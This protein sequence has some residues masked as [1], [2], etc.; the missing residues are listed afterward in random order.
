[1]KKYNVKKFVIASLLVAVICASFL[2]ILFGTDKT[3]SATTKV[4]V[5]QGKEVSVYINGNDVTKSQDGNYVAVAGSTITVTV[6]NESKLFSSMTIN[7]TKY[8]TAVKT[9]TVPSDNNKLTI[10]VDTQEP[11][12]EDKGKYF[13]NPYVLNKEA[14]VLAVARILAG[15]TNESDFAQIGA[16]GKTPDD[17]RYGYYRLG[18]NLFISSQ[19]FFGLGFRGALPFGGCFD[20]DGYI[21]TMNLVRTSHVDSEFS[22]E[23]DTHVADYG[24][25]AYAYGDGV[26]P[27]LIKNVKLQ[28]FIG[29]NTM[30]N[31]ADSE[32]VDHVN[33]GSVAGSAGKNIVFD[34]IESSVSVSAQTRYAD[35]YIG[36]IFGMCSSS[37]EEWCDVR[38]DGAFNDVSGVTY[39]RGAGVVVGAFAGVVQNASIN[40]ITIDGERSMILANALGE[41]SGSA[42]AGGFVGVI[43]LGA[44]TYKEI[45]EPRAMIIKNITIYAES[46]YSVSSVINNSGATQKNKIDPDDFKKTSSAAIAGGIL[47]VVNRGSNGSTALDP[48]MDIL[49]SKV[50]F[51]RS[52]ETNEGS[53]D[54]DKA[55]NGR[56]FIKASTQDAESS[57]VV[58]AGGVVGYIY[59]AGNDYITKKIHELNNVEYIFNCP[60]DITAE[61]NGVGPAYAGGVFGYNSFK[62][63]S[64]DGKVLKI[65]VVS[66]E[67]DYTVTATQS[68]SS[69]K[70]DNYTYYNVCAGGYT[71]RFNIGYD[72]L[73]GEFYLGNG[74]ITA[75]REVGSTAIGDVN[76]G[77]FTGRL[78]GVGSAAMTIND[79]DKIGNPTGTFKNLTMHF[80]DN[81]YVEASCYSFDSVNTTGSLGNNVCAG[82]VV[83]YVI[84]YGS[85]ENVSLIFD[86][87][88]PKAGSPTE[89]FIY[90]A[91]NASY[92]GGDG[93]LKTEGF[94]GGMFGLV[95]DTKISN[96]TL[97]G[98]ETE[99][100]VVYFVS[101]NSPNTASV[102]GLIGALWRRTLKSACTLLDGASIKN[103]HTA[104]RAYCE[105]TSSNDIY[106]IYVG[107]AI[108]VFANP[109]QNKVSTT[110]TDITVDGCVV[111]A[112]GEK[113]M[114]TY[115]GGVV[116]G[117]WWDNSTNLSYG[118]VKNSAI[119]AS[120][121]VPYAYAGGIVGLMQYSTVSY[122][123]TQDTEVKAV[124][125]KAYAYAGG[126]A[127]RCKDNNTKITYCYSNASLNTQG[128]NA[129]A[130][131]KGGIAAR[132]NNSGTGDSDTSDDKA[133]NLFVYETA[134]TL[135][136][137]HKDSDTR[138]L[139]LDSARQNKLSVS[140]GSTTRVYS[141]V[142]TNQ[143][144]TISIKTH[145]KNIASI[146]NGLYVY[147]VS[148]GFTYVGVYCKIN[149]VE[150]LLCSYPVTVANATESGSGISLK[151]DDGKDVSTQQTDAYAKYNYGSGTTE[152]KYLYFRRNIGNTKTIKK[153]NAVPV[154]AD[155]LPQNIKFYDIT[156]VTE[157]KYSDDIQARIKN[158]IESKGSSCDI[159][160][161]NGR[162][163][164]GFN[165]ETSS[166]EG[167]AK[168]S[169]YFYANDNVRK[170]TI[171][172]MECDYGSQ[173]YGVIIE[174]VPNMLTGITITPEKGTPPLGT[175]EKTETNPNNNKTE[176]LTHYI[177]T[178]GD[179]V[180][181]G[182]TL[183]YYY[184]AP[185]SYIVETIYRGTGVTENGMVTVAANG[186]YYV[187]CKDLKNTEGV[188][189]TV[190]VE[191]KEEVSYMFAY[192]GARGTSDRK[193]VESCEFLFDIKP[194]PGYGL[195]P[196]ISITVDGITKNVTFGANK[197]T[198]AFGTNSF[199]FPYIEDEEEQYAYG[200][201]VGTDFVEYVLN[202][203]KTVAFSVAYQK[204]YSLVFISNYNGNDFF[205]MTVAAGEKFAD[206]TAAGF[207]EWTQSIIAGRYGFDFRGF[208]TVSK[209]GD[210]SAYGESFE[211]MQND[212]TSRVSGTM[213]FYA[214]WTYNVTVD[215]PENIKVSSSMTSS[216]LHDGEMI[217][218]DANNDFGFV[219]EATELWC[220]KPRFDAFILQKDGTYVNVTADFTEASQNNSY[221]ISSEIFENYKSGYI[222]IKVY[223]DS[224]E[225]AVGDDARYDG[226]SI[227]TDGIFTLTYNV[228]YGSDD[229]LGSYAFDF[230][231]LYLPIGTSMRLFYQKNG[232]AVWAGSYVLIEKKNQ[233]SISDFKSMRDG[234]SIL[235]NEQ[236]SSAVSEK[237]IIV[238]TLPN[239]SNGFDIT[240]ATVENVSITTYAFSA[241]TKNYGLFTRTGE[242]PDTT[243]SLAEVE[244]TLYPAVIRTMTVSGQTFV[245]AESGSLD[246]NVTDQ[247]HNG[248]R[249]MWRVEK[250]NGGYI[251]DDTFANFGSEVVRTTDAIYYSATP[252][253]VTIDENLSGYRVSLIEVRNIQQPAESLI[254]GSAMF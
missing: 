254:I 115:A 193:M 71:S 37:I 118:I 31:S 155:Y 17:I 218:L 231:P 146:S 201:T 102:G 72:M 133:K 187:T 212:G 2:A 126:I 123:L 26:K 29:L 207:D 145:N 129:D 80:A 141:A 47:G 125:E 167:D 204:I 94:I 120:S 223:A 70:A 90:G 247:R 158:I 214:R 22:Y 211:D 74:K 253:S 243:N 156:G 51:L 66:P 11:Y 138:A 8:Y 163:N 245:F 82:G 56:L 76:A 25:F 194:Q 230:A 171:I 149:G 160:S 32:H 95:I 48:D 189:T 175:F 68:A 222:Y 232:V 127:A 148:A 34:G 119:T 111:D 69:S 242:I 236:R 215:A 19:E 35:L 240:T 42:I 131:K 172:L 142:S 16:T 14:D 43:E 65:G 170:N 4:V 91:Q 216:L 23:N 13:G 52:G 103:V 58:F 217:P 39:G 191:A 33:V 161:F 18:T 249:Y 84:G 169:V 246:E 213:R 144:S 78:L 221:H 20:F 176:T 89:Y 202:N 10:E 195:S 252:G 162:A 186:V 24:F 122:C 154:N 152:I 112:I 12:A 49:F 174:F 203:G 116:A 140:T 178:A 147:G 224:L 184:P 96:V 166:D 93:D 159:S 210:I 117:M 55:E 15:G 41:V 181:F 75:Y 179:V 64:D 188:E 197:L 130:S 165:Y 27:C 226:N 87:T 50:N 59:G 128:V 209:A 107:G 237:F 164:V 98:D 36:G 77:G 244:F 190:V 86:G 46:D 101:T 177:Y 136:A 6:V 38:Y 220:G 113:N 92:T 114:L 227:Y 199:E 225:F 121:I 228:N 132:I 45:S 85:I 67:Y 62:I 198:V 239:N 83:G 53:N 104:G 105:Q 248:V 238:V 60:V 73:G 79:Y 21:A 63:K 251:G 135:E 183:Q 5:P 151:T 110:I 100:S 97:E 3:Y 109:S 108:G 9:I 81:S 192:S 173:T 234:T 134:G 57:G 200:I 233:I 205:S 208:Y 137:Y 61:Q 44:H 157:A 185:R 99:N 206:I 196:T 124:S 40:G 143:S 106:D 241:V 88:T 139:Y 1:M 153:V 229:S 30:N 54:A 28:G 7:G 250:I 168:K 235:T 150:Y 180:R 219:L 182:A